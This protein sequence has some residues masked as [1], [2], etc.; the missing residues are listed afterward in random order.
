MAHDPIAI[1]GIGCRFPG[2]K[3]PESFWRLLSTGVDAIT[4][5][6]PHRFDIADFY[7][8]RPGIPGKLYSRWGGFSITS[9]SSTLTSSAS[10]L[11][12]RPVWIRSI[13]C[14]SKWRGRRSRMPDNCRISW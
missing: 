10:R 8:P 6:P 5:V 13:D 14:C 12:K 4:E 1:T 2:A 11:V 9:M 7:D 3:E